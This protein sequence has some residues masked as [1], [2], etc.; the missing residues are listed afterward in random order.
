MEVTCVLTLI[1][2]RK[3]GLDMGM[4]RG[5]SGNQAAKSQVGLIAASLPSGPGKRR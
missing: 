3:R 4:G 2:L 5:F 1:S